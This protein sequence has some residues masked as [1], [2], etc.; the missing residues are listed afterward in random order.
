MTAVLPFNPNNQAPTARAQREG[1]KYYAALR[2]RLP[3]YW[4][5]THK[6]PIGGGRWLHKL[7]DIS[8]IVSIDEEADGRI[9]LHFSIA[10]PPKSP[11]PDWDMVKRARADFLG[12]D[13]Y[14]YMVFPPKSKW[15]N[16]HPNALHLFLPLS[17]DLPLPD[18]TRGGDSI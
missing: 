1:V 14:A 3:A 17:G 11:L 9:W 4:Q 18:F 10:T 15:V 13:D 16:Q 6:D 7:T 8:V 2:K 5:H 12:E